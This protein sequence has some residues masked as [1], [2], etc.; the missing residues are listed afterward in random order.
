MNIAKHLL[1]QV[2]EAGHCPQA[3]QRFRRDEVGSQGAV[4]VVSFFPEIVVGFFSEDRLEFFQ[5]HGTFLEW[6]CYEYERQFE[7]SGFN[8]ALNRDFS[9]ELGRLEL[10]LVRMMLLQPSTMLS[11]RQGPMAS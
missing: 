6:T 9:F 8:P 1:P 5:P 7:A 2:E 10:V 4:L 11:Y 3:L